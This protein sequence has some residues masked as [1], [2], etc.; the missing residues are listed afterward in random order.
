MGEWGGVVTF[1]GHNLRGVVG[2]HSRPLV[3]AQPRDRIFFALEPSLRRLT[4]AG[5]GIPPPPHD[6]HSLAK[7]LAFPSA[8][9]ADHAEK[10]LHSD[11][12]TLPWLQGSPDIYAERGRLVVIKHR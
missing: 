2:F 11:Q 6:T 1:A 5:P 12:L 4:A 9:G 7:T 8:T 10:S 3:L